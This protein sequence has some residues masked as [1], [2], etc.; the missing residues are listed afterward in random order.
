[1]HDGDRSAPMQPLILLLLHAMHVCSQSDK[2]ASVQCAE[3]LPSVPVT[4]HVLITHVQPCPAVS[5]ASGRLPPG[6]VLLC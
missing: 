6:Q 2:G 4:A 3:A 5:D 1:M